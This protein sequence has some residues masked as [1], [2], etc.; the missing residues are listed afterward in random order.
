CSSSFSN[1]QRTLI[2]FLVYYPDGLT[3]IK[4]VDVSDAVKN[5]QT[6]VNL[7]FE[8]VEWVGPS[9]VVHIV[10]DNAAKYTAIVAIRLLSQIFSSSGCERNW[11]VFEQIHTKKRNILEHQRLNDIVFV[12]YNLRLKNRYFQ[13]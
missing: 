1:R 9:N 6:L 3:F 7:F 12:T 4:S 10:T 13:F 5:A 8:V 11:S 2:N